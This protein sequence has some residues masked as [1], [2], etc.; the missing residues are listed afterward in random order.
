LQKIKDLMVAGLEGVSIEPDGSLGF[1]FIID[2]SSR[3]NAVLEIH[4]S[5]EKGTAIHLKNLKMTETT[6]SGPLTPQELH[7]RKQV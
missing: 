7:R 6:T 4:S 2:F 3:I 1:Q 5:K